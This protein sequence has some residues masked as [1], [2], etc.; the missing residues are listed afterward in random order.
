MENMALIAIM[1]V[2][3][4]MEYVRLLMAH[5]DVMQVGSV[6]SAIHVFVNMDF[7]VQNVLR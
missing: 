3:V 4:K 7:M 5:V 1:I 6:I 2:L